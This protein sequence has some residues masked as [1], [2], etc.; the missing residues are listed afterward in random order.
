MEPVGWSSLLRIRVPPATVG[1]P[2]EG[3]VK[4]ELRVP[5]PPP[6][7][8]LT[9]LVSVR[10]FTW[11]LRMAPLLTLKAAR[12]LT[13]LKGLVRPVL[14]GTSVQIQQLG[15]RWATVAKVRPSR[16][17]RFG[18]EPSAP[19]GVYRARVVPGNGWAVA[20]SPKVSLQ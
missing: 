7:A 9:G 4:V 15:R 6:L 13:T 17:G 10:L 12:D 5:M 20:L 8:T 2:A 1:M 19:G 14:R 3:S 16:Y 11:P 18:F